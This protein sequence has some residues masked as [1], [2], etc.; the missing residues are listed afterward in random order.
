MF[1]TNTSELTMEHNGYMFCRMIGIEYNSA[2]GQ[3]EKQMR[4]LLM[5]GLFVLLIVVVGLIVR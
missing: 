2:S 1:V 4:V 5:K 3:Y